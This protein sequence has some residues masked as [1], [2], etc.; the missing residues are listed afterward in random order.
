[1]TKRL[2]KRAIHRSLFVVSHEASRTGAPRA[3][4]EIVR[5]L[6]LP[7]V[8]LTVILR[9]PGP[10]RQEFEAAADT[11]V[12]E[13]FRRFRVLLRSRRQTRLLAVRVEQLA[14]AWLLLGRRPALVYLNTV[15]SACYIRPAIL[16][17]RP[18]V[19]HVHELE[20]LVSETLARYQLDGLFVRLRLVACSAAVRDN[21]ARVTGVAPSDIAVIPSTIDAAHV[22]EQARAAPA[23]V[24]PAGRL[25]VGACGTADHR[26]G[27]DLWL[28][29][30]ARVHHHEMGKYVHFVWVGQPSIPDLQERVRELGVEDA[31][32]F[33]GEVENP[34]P[35]IAAMDIF[36]HSARQDPFPLAVLEA[37]AL[38]RPVVAFAV[39][40]VKD[41]LGEAGVLV[42]PG[43]AEALAA[44]VLELV[45]DQ[46]RRAELG[47]QARARAVSAFGIG[48][49]RTAVS[50]LVAEELR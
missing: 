14:A 30:A 10:L 8:H 40:G 45:E 46:G 26:K 1:M 41:Q 20:P 16:M 6:A 29:M 35:D 18:V 49:F 21:L 50:D 32:T 2:W 44:A 19:L 5:S 42:P 34:Y 28:E 13:P 24:E 43:D 48:A 25:V 39:N 9:W 22:A 23:Y 47:A 4:V 17:R 33:T 36:T 7:G 37:M 38:G 27:T 15:K 11:V 3:A 12:L 31:V